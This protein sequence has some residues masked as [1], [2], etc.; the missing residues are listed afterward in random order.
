MKSLSILVNIN[1]SFFQSDGEKKLLINESG[2]GELYDKSNE[3]Y[4]GKDQ[5]ITSMENGFSVVIL[6]ENRVFWV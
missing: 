4:E 2:Q 1:S 5:N 6:N 3:L